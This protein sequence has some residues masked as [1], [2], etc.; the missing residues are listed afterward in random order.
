MSRLIDTKLSPIDE[1]AQLIRAE[2]NPGPSPAIIDGLKTRAEERENMLSDFVKEVR[3][4]NRERRRVLKM[5]LQT[6]GPVAV[7]TGM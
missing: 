3:E 6:R 5:L 7:E 1:T 2:K 4:E